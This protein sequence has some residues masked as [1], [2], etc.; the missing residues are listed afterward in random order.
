M[1]MDCFFLRKLNYFSS[2]NTLLCGVFGW[3]KRKER[4]LK[5]GRIPYLNRKI[6]ENKFG[7]DEI[8]RI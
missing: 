6:G 3:K 1:N 4:Y 7:G 2:P 8:K 5:G